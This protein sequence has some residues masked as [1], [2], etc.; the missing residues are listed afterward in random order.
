MRYRVTEIK[1]PPSRRPDMEKIV[2]ATEKKVAKALHCSAEKVTIKDPEIIRQ[3]IDARKKPDVKMVYNVD[4]D[5]DGQLPFDKAVKEAAKADAF[6]FP[7]ELAEGMKETREILSGLRKSRTAGV[8]ESDPAENY[9]VCA[10]GA[11]ASISVM[12]GPEGGFEEEEVILAEQAGIVP[13]TLGKR[14]LRTETAGL[15][16]LSL[17]MAEAELYEEERKQ[18]GSI[19][20]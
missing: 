16:I 20:G 4:F 18:S 17:V 10:E 2:K 5:F 11:P 19:S 3:S 14:I 1:T 7:Y 8:T 6:L 9:S 12:I 13:V 15:C